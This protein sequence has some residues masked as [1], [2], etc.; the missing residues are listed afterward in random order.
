[1]Y[2]K[3]YYK[4]LEL[5]P[6][7]SLPEIKKAYRRLALQFHP[8]KTNNDAYSAAQF[9]DIKEAYEVLTNP[10][11]KEYYLQQRWY[12]QSAGRKR[13]A[14]VVT[15]VSVLKQALE[16]EKYVSR[17]DVHRMDKLGLYEY[18]KEIASDEIAEKLNQFNEPAIKKEIVRLLVNCSLVLMPAQFRELMGQ[19]KKIAGDPGSVSMLDE[20]LYQLQQKEKRAKYKPVLLFVVVIAICILIYLLSA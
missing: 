6:S 8:D 16:L 4:I 1:M 2:L 18:I 15:P 5:E 7:A 20:K 10:S 19:F 11:R 3:D 9:T 12:N 14:T 17:L 13:T